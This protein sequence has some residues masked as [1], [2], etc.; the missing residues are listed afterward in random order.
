[1]SLFFSGSCLRSRPV[2]GAWI[3]ISMTRPTI[4]YTS[5]RAP[6]GARGLKYVKQMGRRCYAESRPVWGAWIEI[7]EIFYHQGR[8]YRRA[9]YGA[10]GLKFEQGLE[11]T[12]HRWSRPVWGA[13]IEMWRILCLDT[14]SIVAPRMGRVD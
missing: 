9:P 3:E 12:R 5:S 1:M 11:K 10:R 13:W 7:D 2:W 8:K 4:P 6:Y 14:D